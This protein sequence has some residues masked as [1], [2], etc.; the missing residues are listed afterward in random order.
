MHAGDGTFRKV[1]RPVYRTEYYY[2]TE[3][4]PV[5]IWVPKSEVD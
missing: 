2:E 4:V 3:Q 1:A 5:Y